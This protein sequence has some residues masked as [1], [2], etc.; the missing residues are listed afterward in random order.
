MKRA[1]VITDQ[2]IISRIY[3]VRGRKVMI[4][5]DLAEL[6]G[7]ETRV[8]NQAVKRNINRFPGDFMF[9]LS[10]SE[11]DNWRSQIEISMKEKMGLRKPPL[12]FTEQG[13][14]MLSSVLNSETAIDVNI[15]IIRIFTG[16]REVIVT[17][18]DMLLKLE[19][20]EKKILKNEEYYKKH[21]DEIQ[22]IFTAL[23]RL[24]HS[25]PEPRKKI[26]YKIN[27]EKEQRIAANS[28]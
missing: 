24:V 17:H 16:V 15:Q 8:L 28:F 11:M 7:V 20:L 14:A 22:T 21:E 19:Q 25:A 13:V 1:L 10:I 5:R 9:Q 18:K 6:Y 4:D 3:L 2:K 23:K 26:G 27:S 12:A